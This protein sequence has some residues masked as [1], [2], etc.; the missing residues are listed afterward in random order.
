VSVQERPRPGYDALGLRA[1]AFQVYPRLTARIDHQ[2]NIFASD[3]RPVDDMVY[4]LQ[5][6]VSLRSDWSRHAL[7]ADAQASVVRHA[8]VR[9]EDS[10]TWSAGLNGRLDVGR[11]AE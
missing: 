4:A 1:G 6:E 3:D 10:T 7:S 11:T 8:E 9:S 2:D 5:P